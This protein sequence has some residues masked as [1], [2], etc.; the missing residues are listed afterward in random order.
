VNDID[1]SCHAQRTTTGQARGHLHVVRFEVHRASRI[2]AASR[3]DQQRS[4]IAGIPCAI[5]DV[6]ARVNNRPRPRLFDG[7]CF[8][9]INLVFKRLGCKQ[10]TLQK[11]QAGETL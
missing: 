11:S 6:F 4:A 10:I 1:Q 9:E 7:Q 2:V 5:L 3:V 8:H